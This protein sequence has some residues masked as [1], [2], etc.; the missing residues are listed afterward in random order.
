MHI[1]CRNG[2][3][4]GSGHF[5]KKLPPRPS[6]QKLLRY[7]KVSLSLTPASG[8][9]PDAPEKS[10]K[11]ADMLTRLAKIVTI[12]ALLAL[13]GCATY[14]T[15]NVTAFNAWRDSGTDRSYAFAPAPAQRNSIEDATYERWVG[16]ELARHG[17]TPA[18][19]DAARYLVSLRYSLGHRTMVLA[20]P[21][22]Y[23]PW[24]GPYWGGGPLGWGGFGPFGGPPG[25]MGYVDRP[26]E[27]FTHELTVRIVER[28]GGNEVYKVSAVNSGAEPSLLRAMPYLIRSAFAA[29]PMAN[30]T[31]QQVRLPK[32]QSRDGVEIQDVTPAAANERIVP[33][34]VDGA[35]DAGGAA[36]P[37]P[38]VATQVPS[39]P[40]AAVGV[41]GRGTNPPAP[42]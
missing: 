19:P 30:G 25:P 10:F 31:V 40:P 33:D 5:T 1:A 29:F 17:F 24:P 35:D 23:D 3:P 11:E 2:A 9:A 13:S 18:A 22:Y 26:Y 39:D 7:K 15:S 14:V 38:A 12:A 42:R 34:G 28:A 8:A 27:L 32:D 37:V 36:P 41:P 16:A 20:Q 21:V 4:G 6:R